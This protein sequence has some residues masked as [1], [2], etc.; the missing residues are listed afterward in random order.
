MAARYPASFSAIFGQT[1]ILAVASTD[2]KDSLA[3]DSNYGA[4]V[5]DLAAPGVN[6]LSTN[7]TGGYQFDSGTSCAAP[8][9]SGA[10][11]LRL[12]ACAHDTARLRKLLLDS[13]DPIPCLPS[14]PE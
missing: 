2:N 11:L 9:V 6:I 8:H 10:A 12:S 1:N 7:I 14:A 4:T 3:W 5:V 13:V